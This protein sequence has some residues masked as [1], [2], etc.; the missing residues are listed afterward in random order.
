[1]NQTCSNKPTEGDGNLVDPRHRLHTEPHHEST[2]GNQVSSSFTE[3]PLNTSAT[4]T[5]STPFFSQN[6]QQRKSA[7]Q[8]MLRYLE[9][10]P[11]D[12]SF[13]RELCDYQFWKCVRAEFLSSLLFVVF[14]SFLSLNF[15]PQTPIKTNY[16]SSK[17]SFQMRTPGSQQQEN[18]EAIISLNNNHDKSTSTCVTSALMIGFVTAALMYMTANK[19]KNYRSCHLNP[20]LTLALFVT[21]HHDDSKARHVSLAKMIFFTIVQ[22]LASVVGGCILYGLTFSYTEQT[23]EQEHMTSSNTSLSL[24]T[25]TIFSSL[26]VPSPVNGLP[27]SNLFGFEFM[28]SFMVVLVYFSVTDPRSRHSNDLSRQ[29]RGIQSRDQEEGVDRGNA[30]HT[31]KA[32]TRINGNKKR[33]QEQDDRIEDDSTSHLNSVALQTRQRREDEKDQHLHQSKE[34]SVTQ[35]LVKPTQVTGNNRTCS[36]S[37]QRDDPQA[38]VASSSQSSGHTCTPKDL[39]QKGTTKGSKDDDG[40]Q[41]KLLQEE[42]QQ[43]QES[44]TDYVSTKNSFRGNDRSR[45]SSVKKRNKSHRQSQEETIFTQNRIHGRVGGG[46]HGNNKEIHYC[47]LFVGLAMTAAHL[48]CVSTPSIPFFS[49]LSV[50]EG[51]H[52]EQ[53]L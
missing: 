38:Q 19:I 25:R 13:R 37:Q 27:V 24:K 52:M 50:R 18:I 36:S 12:V 1:M 15:S 42:P 23:L 45:N 4:N 51:D 32:S 39:I 29:T 41:E 2:Q 53:I 16:E 7:I 34:E 30:F 48:F 40:Y 5:L 33:E 10:L 20:F 47:F 26:S 14:S 44:L 31:R 43:E 28:A 11:P 9:S 8:A 6:Q 46:P 17:N 35:R 21:R 3:V 49:C 22:L